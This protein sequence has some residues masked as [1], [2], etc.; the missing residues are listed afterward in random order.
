MSSTLLAAGD[1]LIKLWPQAKLTLFPKESQREDVGGYN[2]FILCLRDPKKAFFMIQ[3]SLFH[4]NKKIM[5][6]F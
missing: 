3:I 6:V 5:L 1:K 4:D 2:F